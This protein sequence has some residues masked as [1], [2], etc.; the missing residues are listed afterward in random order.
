[1]TYF[2][3]ENLLGVARAFDG[4]RS[5]VRYPGHPACPEIPHRAE[6]RT[7]LPVVGRAGWIVIMR[8]KKIRTRPG[9][10]QALMANGVRA[11]CLTSSGNSSSWEIASLLMR[12]WHRIEER[13]NAPGPY[14]Y[15]VTSRGVLAL[16]APPAPRSL[17]PRGG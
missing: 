3:D 7:W 13:A 14:I 2:F 11:F 9:E 8:D 4:L 1:M 6:D 15:S 16:V 12:W 10:R 17:G 5:D